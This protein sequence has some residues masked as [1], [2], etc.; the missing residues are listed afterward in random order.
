ML[1]WLIGINQ[2]RYF[3]HRLAWFYVHKKWPEHELDHINLD[4]SDNRIKN[5]REVTHANNMKNVKIR[6]H[7]STGFKGVILLRPTKLNR[8]KRDRYVARIVVDDKMI[9]LGNYDTPD[10]AHAAYAD[11]SQKHHGKHGRAN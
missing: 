7:N 1:Y 5:L 3:A 2:T 9:Y 11:A 4:K 6:K 10:A 8:N